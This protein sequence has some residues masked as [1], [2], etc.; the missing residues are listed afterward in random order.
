M[1]SILTKFKILP[2]KTHH[3]QSQNTNEKLRENIFKPHAIDKRIFSLTMTSGNRKMDKR[4]EY[5]SY[6]RKMGE[7]QE[8]TSLM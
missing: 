2:G 4:E 7:R 5:T 6:H 1:K 3:K 8:Y